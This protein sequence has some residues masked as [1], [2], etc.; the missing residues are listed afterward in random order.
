MRTELQRIANVLGIN[1]TLDD[2]RLCLMIQ[3]KIKEKDKQVKEKTFNYYMIKSQKDKLESQ[4]HNMKN[5]YAESIGIHEH[6]MVKQSKDT[7][8]K[9]LNKALEENHKLNETIRK[10][11][12]REFKDRLKK[13]EGVR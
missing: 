12:E 4:I 13:I 1:T 2:N 3:D 10:Y 6:M 9:Q 11:T 7:I 5:E 8:K